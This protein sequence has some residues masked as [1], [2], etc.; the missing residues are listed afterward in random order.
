MKKLS[1]IAIGCLAS[2]AISVIGAGTANAI[3]TPTPVTGS[4][5]TGSASGFDFEFWKYIATGSSTG[6]NTGSFGN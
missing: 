5:S 4:S 3:G 2:A 6:A 1:V